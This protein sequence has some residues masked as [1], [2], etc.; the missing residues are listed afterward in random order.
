MEMPFGKFKGQ[1]IS[2][3]PKGYLRWLE[4]NTA[5]RGAVAD[6]VYDVL[7]GIPQRPVKNED[8]IVQDIEAQMAGL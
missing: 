1:E 6:E 7:R 2:E 8:D 5:L 4:N 3:I